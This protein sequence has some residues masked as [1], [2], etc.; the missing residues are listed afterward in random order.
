MEPIRTLFDR[1]ATVSPRALPEELLKRYDGD[2]QF[3]APA[4]PYVFANFAETLD[5]VVS[6]QIPGKSGGAEITGHNATDRFIMGLLRASADA[7]LVGSKSFEDVSP[8]HIWTAEYI[9]PDAVPLYRSYRGIERKAPLNVIV[10]GSGRIDVT[11]AVFHTPGVESLVITTPEGKRRI[12]EACHMANASVQTR[13]ISGAPI[14][15][16][17]MIELLHAEFGVMRL[18]HE[19]GPALFGQFLRDR[20][21]DE[22]FLTISPQIAGRNLASERLALVRDAAF[23]PENAPWMQLLSVKQ[24]GNHLFLRYRNG[25][26]AE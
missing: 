13:V 19:G 3:P 20:L 15:P 5:G 14:A 21:I 23:T 2:L 18:L 24:A 11:R 6:Y 26:G 25:A 10:S 22:L 17:R 16:K 1:Q 9:Y 12:E 8:S 7:V 4:R